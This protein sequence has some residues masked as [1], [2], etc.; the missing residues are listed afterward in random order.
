MDNPSKL[1]REEFLMKARS[2]VIGVDVAK[3]FCYYAILNPTGQVHI[4]SFKASSNS[5]GLIFVLGEIQKVEK[6]FNSKPVIVLESTGHYSNRLVH[7]FTNN[8]FRVFLINPLLSHSIKNSTVRKVKTD[9]VDAEELAKLYFFMN[10]REYQ[11]QTKHIEN[12][13]ILTRTYHHLSQQRVSIINQLKATLDQ[14]MP[15]FK[16]VYK[17]IAGKTP[18]E[19]LL[20]YPS[21][22]NFLQAP[23]DDIIHIIRANARVSIE[24]AQKKYVQILNSAKDGQKSGI[25]FNAYSQTITIHVKHLKHIN[26]Q[27][28]SINKNIEAL[29]IDIPEIP[30][31]QSI[32]G[33]GQKLAPIIAAEI[34]DINRF[35][36]SKQLVAYCGIDPSVRQSGDFVGT[37]NKFTKRGSIYIRKAL[38]MA[39]V[40]AI[41][42]NPNG[43]YVNKVIY[44]YYHK[45]IQSKPRKKVLGAVMNKLVR[46]I[47]SVLKNQHTFVLITPEEQV[48]MY[49]SNM[50]I[51]S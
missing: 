12:L 19:L 17:N 3:D 4:K 1:Y 2:P 37:K 31:L 13:K 10:L 49:R 39:A 33:I 42:K 9:K 30:L 25:L 51:A 35:K 11:I 7:F 48:K 6:T 50:K 15:E 27:L 46:I 45:K 29:A 22:S 23:K 38:Y 18:L 40:I 24:Y 16:K 32:P 41:R 20:Q 34:G 8:D 14:I 47:F 28:V 43:T 21:P 36:N 26:E 44:D 5:E